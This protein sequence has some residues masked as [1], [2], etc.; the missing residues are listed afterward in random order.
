MN[1]HDTDG[2]RETRLVHDVHRRATSLLAQM[3]DDDRPLAAA[4]RDFVVAM[5]EHHHTCED[6]GL[7]PMLTARAPGLDD[8]LRALTAEHDRLQEH[9]DR[10]RHPADD[11]GRAHASERAVALRDLVHE[12]LDHEE[13]VLFPALDRYISDDDWEG[14]SRRTIAVAPTEGVPFLLALLD[15]VGTTAE[16]ELIFRNLPPDARAA[17]RGRR[18]EGIRAL[19]ELRATSTIGHVR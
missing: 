6:G 13:P 16:A 8:A 7:W 19:A 12:H 5:L 10:L 1:R 18:A 9:L 15:E 3:G 2:V 4:Y 17:I 11:T 14:F